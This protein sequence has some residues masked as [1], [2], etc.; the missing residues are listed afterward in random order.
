MSPIEKKWPFVVIVAVCTVLTTM[1]I[2]QAAGMPSMT[3][4]NLAQGVLYFFCFFGVWRVYSFL[5]W[6]LVLWISPKT[7]GA[8][9]GEAGRS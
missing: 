8:L 1:Y 6:L 9:R 4:E 7:A 2:M 3:G 5:G